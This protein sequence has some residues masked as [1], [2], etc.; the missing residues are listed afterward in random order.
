MVE[1]SK[2]TDVYLSGVVREARLEGAL[3][4]ISIYRVSELWGGGR[5]PGEQYAWK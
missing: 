2:H 1:G 5:R 3:G 4:A